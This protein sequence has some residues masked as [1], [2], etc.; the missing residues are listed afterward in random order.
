ME[1]T[2]TKPLADIHKVVQLNAP[3]EKVWKAIATSDGL[4]SW[5]MKNTFKPILG[6]EFILQTDQFGDSP[7]KVTEIT[8]PTKLCID[9][10][11][12]WHLTFEL[13]E[14]EDNKCELSFI[15]SGWDETK[16]TIFGQPH[17]VIRKVMDDGWTNMIQN[18][19]PKKLEK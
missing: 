12:D 8:P 10:D 3:I 5:W 15:H 16:K 4:A 17:T 7:C 6:Y 18:K 9:W 14:L 19:L 13:Q 11:K 2:Q 1:Q